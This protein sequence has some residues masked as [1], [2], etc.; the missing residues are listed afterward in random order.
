MFIGRSFVDLNNQCNDNLMFKISR[1]TYNKEY[2][3]NYIIGQY[4]LPGS[5]MRVN[6]LINLEI[7]NNKNKTVQ[8]SSRLVFEDDISKFI[9]NYKKEGILYKIVNFNNNN[10]N[11]KFI[12]TVYDKNKNLTYIYDP[13]YKANQRVYIKNLIGKKCNSLSSNC[14]ITCYKLDNTIV[15]G[16]C[17]ELIISQLE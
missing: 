4:P 15:D 13:S 7:N 9:D 3:D 1:V 5:L 17:G 10:N 2:E 6:Q 14:M 11:Y 12:I 8:N 16:C